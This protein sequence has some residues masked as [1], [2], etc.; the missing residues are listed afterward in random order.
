VRFWL[1]E[2]A[3]SKYARWPMRG[4]AV[5]GATILGIALLLGSSGSA[6]AD[7]GTLA[8]SLFQQGVGAMER[9]DFARAC[10]LLA[11]SQRLDPG[12][13]TL[14]N[15]GLCHERAGHVA[16]AWARYHDALGLARRDERPDRITFAE[17]HIKLL[18]P[19][20]PRLAIVMKEAVAGARVKVDGAE[21]SASAWETPSPVDPGEHQLRVEA[22]GRR[23]YTVAIAVREGETKHVTVPPLVRDVSIDVEGPHH[24]H[25]GRTQRVL[26]WS[27]TGV[28]GG[29]VVAAAVLGALA[30][31]AESTA[32]AVC[33]G[34]GACASPRGLDASSRA[35][36]FATAASISGIAGVVMLAGGLVMVLTAP[37]PAPPAPAAPA[38]H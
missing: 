6:R 11:E 31:S 19:R 17:E 25:A 24:A 9:G 33:P 13:G 15:L 8:E 20:L 29:A 28:G 26:G 16:T 34:A 7:E 2:G 18:E 10:E 35:S 36:S 32:N 14:L 22:P 3:P 21:L 12:G 5:L 1:R 30:I 4:A 37:S 23:V 27:L 38:A